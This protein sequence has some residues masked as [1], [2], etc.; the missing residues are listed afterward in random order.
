M[1]DKF[2]A[3]SG[4][5]MVLNIISISLDFSEELHLTLDSTSQ[6]QRHLPVRQIAVVSRASSAVCKQ[7]FEEQFYDG[8]LIEGQDTGLYDAMNIGLRHC[9]PGMVWFINGGDEALL[10]ARD[11]V[12]SALRAP[13]ICRCFRTI[14]YFNE[15]AWVRPGSATPKGPKWL[16][17]QGFLAPIKMGESELLIF[18]THKLIDADFDWMK[19]NIEKWGVDYSER[20]VSRYALGGVSSYPSIKAIIVRL[21]TQ[22]LLMALKEVLKLLNRA[23]IGTKHHYKILAFF[24]RYDAFNKD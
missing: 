15:L 23:V 10:E 2:E 18:N 11:A 13:V 24:S 22:G 1:T 8:C 6:L 4:N 21:R 20:V 17:H 12:A 16:G 5:P 7:W 14:Q 19:R 9:K 3:H